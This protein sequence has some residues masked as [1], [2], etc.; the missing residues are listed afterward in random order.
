MICKK[1]GN[2]ITWLN[3][4]GSPYPENICY[5]CIKNKCDGLVFEEHNSIK[6]D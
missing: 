4:A 2:K 6:W 3:V 1:C 5:D